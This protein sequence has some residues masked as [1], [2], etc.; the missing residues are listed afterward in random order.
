[1]NFKL[2]FSLTAIALLASCN[3]SDKQIEDWVSK[4]PDKIIKALMDHQKQEQEKNSPKPEMVKE[5]SAELFNSNSPSMGSGPIK[6]A[7]FFDFNCGHCSKQS[8][9]IK[10]VLKKTDKVQVFYKNHTVLGPTS[11][12]AAQ[13]A[14]AAHQQKKFFEFY[15]EIYKTRDKNMDSLKAIAKKLKLDMKKWEADMQG[16]AVTQELGSVQQLAAKMRIGGTP[17]LAISPDK[18]FP[19]RVDQL[20]QVVESMN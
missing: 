20:M 4:N 9:T 12:L 19:G 6:I 15:N 10:E 1:M 8:E 16:E 3:A 18:V 13:A 7:Y 11:R 14:L 17:F 2:G 5:N